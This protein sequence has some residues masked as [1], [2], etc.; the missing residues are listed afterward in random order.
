MTK[1]RHDIVLNM[2]LETKSEVLEKLTVTIK[3]VLE[4][5]EDVIPDSVRVYFD[6]IDNEAI[7]L[8]IYLYTQITNYDDFLEFKTK[9]NLL[10]V[11][12]L[13]MDGIHV[14]YPGNAIYLHS[15]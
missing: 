7:K 15:K 13:E 10:V 6:K 8:K 3:S 2:P 14:S 9:V 1:R 11:R 5:D 12:A 4:A